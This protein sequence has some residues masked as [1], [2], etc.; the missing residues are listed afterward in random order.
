MFIRI[1]LTY[2]L[3]NEDQMLQSLRQRERARFR[4]YLEGQLFLLGSSHWV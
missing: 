3:R 1:V 2:R 4:A